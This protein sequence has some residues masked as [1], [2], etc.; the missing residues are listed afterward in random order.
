[1]QNTSGIFG[2]ASMS[3]ACMATVAAILASA[4]P[5]RAA[6]WIEFSD[7]AQQF[8]VSLPGQPSVEEITT[9]SW[10]GVTVPARVYTV[11]DGASRYT[12]TVIDYSS[13]EVVT[14]VLGGIAHEAWKVRKRGGEITWDA[15]TQADRIAGHEIYLTNAD[16]SLTM[17]AIFLHHRRLYMLEATVPAGMPPPLLF[18]QSFHVFDEEGVRVRY[19]ID[20]E[21]QRTA[22]VPRDDD[23][24]PPA[25]IADRDN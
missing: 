16:R 2:A 21:G 10:R 5:A 1:M 23:Y 24:Q 4:A 11:V 18:Q 3:L 17:V 25:D 20:A 14:D 12:V 13:V 19:E 15:Y 8:G 9:T 22:R 6:D 7:R